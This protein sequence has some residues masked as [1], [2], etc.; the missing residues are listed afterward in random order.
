[1]NAAAA[2]HLVSVNVAVNKGG[3]TVSTGQNS[4]DKCR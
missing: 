1:M 4:E 3:E 2:R